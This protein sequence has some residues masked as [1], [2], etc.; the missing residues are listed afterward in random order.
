MI[1]ALGVLEM[2]TIDRMG[3]REL[4]DAVGR[5][6]DC[7]PH[8]LQDDLDAQPTE[9]LRLLLLAARSIFALRMTDHPEV[10]ASPRGS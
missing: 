4:L 10:M 1:F 6:R 7:L 5:R 2:L 8:D 3:R 9:R